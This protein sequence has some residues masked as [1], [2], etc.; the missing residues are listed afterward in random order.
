MKKLA[1]FF[2][3]IAVFGVGLVAVR[4]RS[5][6]PPPSA[7]LINDTVMT[8][9]AMSYEEIAAAGPFLTAQLNAAFREM[10]ELRE[11]RDQAMR[12]FMYLFIAAFALAGVAAFMY[13]ERTI[14][15]P[16]RRMKD[17]SR[18]VAEGDLDA[19]L[20]M[21]KQNR[22]GAFTESFDIMREELRKAVQSKKELVATLSHDIKTPIASI[23]AVTEL[24]LVTTAD[25]KAQARLN[26]IT[27]KAEQVNAL[28]TNMF[29]ATLEELQV[30][31]VTPEECG[32][33]EIATMLTNADYEGR[34]VIAP[35][36]TCLMV[37]DMLRLQQVFDNV[38]SNAYKYADTSIAIKAYFA[39]G[40]LVIDIQDFGKGVPDAE[41]PHL[42]DKFYRGGNKD[43]ISGQGLGLYIS[44]YF[45]KQMQGDMVCENRAD[46]FVVKVLIKLA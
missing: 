3:L 1:L 42:F 46:G 12:R 22:F 10:D 39:N 43:K 5:V 41:L 36:P 6:A 21:D 20:A 4:F 25:E 11:S 40:H 26:T 34:A 19:P 30:L 17:F 14:L 33:T 24:M 18:S 13:C 15:L 9:S 8:V 37:A 16:F 45:M 27:A 44:H 29:H 35:I 28:I 7:V 31:H 23:K 2:L 32:S 38:I